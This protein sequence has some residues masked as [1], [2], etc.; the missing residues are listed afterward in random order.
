[1]ATTKETPITAATLA[2]SIAKLEADFNV[3]LGVVSA[4]EEAIA[5]S[6]AR[7]LDATA[8]L[9]ALGDERNT[10]AGQLAALKTLDAQHYEAA[11]A[12][13]DAAIA[14]ILAR[15]TSDYREVEIELKDSIAKHIA[16][17]LTKHGLSGS[18]LDTF[19]DAALESAWVSYNT[20]AADEQRA[21][22]PRFPLP[23]PRNEL[24]QPDESLVRH[25]R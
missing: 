9:S 14:E 19:L 16:P 15:A 22:G 8:L 13:R 10:L 20:R 2:A 5:G 7:G 25:A 18:N 17:L 11:Q 3:Q 4:T 24:G 6:Y 12:E 21:L 1:M 23:F